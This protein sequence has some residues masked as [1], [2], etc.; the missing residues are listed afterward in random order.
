MHDSQEQE[1]LL[2]YN[3]IR[4]P[5]HILQAKAS[6]DPSI[7]SAI[8]GIIFNVADKLHKEK[9]VSFESVIYELNKYQML[10][11]IGGIDTINAIKQI[12]IRLDDAAFTTLCRDLAENGKLNKVKEILR[13]LSNRDGDTTSDDLISITINELYK[14]RDTKNN[15]IITIDSAL[16]KPVIR[17]AMTGTSITN[18]DA[19]IDGFVPGEYVVVAARP[20]IGKTALATQ[21]AVDAT[22]NNIPVLFFSLEQSRSAL[23]QRMVRMV[24]NDPDEL[25]GLPMLLKCQ[26]GVTFN[27]IL[28]ATQI[29]IM[30]HD[31]KIVFIDYIGLIKGQERGESRNDFIGRLS[32]NLQTMARQLNIC[33]VA[34][35]QLN[36]E[37]ERE[38]REPATYDLRD[39]GSLE[40]DADIIILLHRPNRGDR[41]KII[42]GKHREGNIGTINASFNKESVM[43]EDE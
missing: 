5:N 2:L 37:S 22:F 10:D 23:T 16:D 26:S 17:Q 30:T 28:A 3:I 41:S 18:L 15:D 38:G 19:I 4:T 12:G 8:G 25:R 33:V 6:I 40:Q 11:S 7:L 31:V 24:D 9:N 20:S 1:W 35:S 36:R 32:Q 39:S 43:F 34:L 21:M 29:A 14:V 42:V 27:Q 13:D